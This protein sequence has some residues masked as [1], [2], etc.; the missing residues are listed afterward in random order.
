MTEDA[1]NFQ[2]TA[3]S[4]VLKASEVCSHPLLEVIVCENCKRVIKEKMQQVLIYKMIMGQFYSSTTIKL[5]MM[6]FAN[7]VIF[8][9]FHLIVIRR[10]F[11]RIFVFF[12]LIVD[13]IITLL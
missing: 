8:S 10:I 2:C 12:F 7:A 9:L 3:C 6:R 5:K 11:Y 13:V 4:S 1:D